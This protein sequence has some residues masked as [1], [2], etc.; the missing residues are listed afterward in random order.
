[1]PKISNFRNMMKE[2]VH[3]YHYNITDENGN[4]VFHHSPLPI[5]N[6]HGTVK[7]HGT[8]AAICYNKRDCFWVQSKNRIITPSSD[9]IAAAST[10]I[11]SQSRS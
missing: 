9:E 4:G 3:D 7:I 8:C 11:L 6:A 5:V 2:I 10:P 1:M